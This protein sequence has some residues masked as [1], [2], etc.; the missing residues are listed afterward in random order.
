MRKCPVTDCE[1]GCEGICLL[2]IAQKSPMNQW[3]EASE[4][5]PPIIERNTDQETCRY[6]DPRAKTE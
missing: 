1:C 3:V 5:P 4:A 2:W 6:R